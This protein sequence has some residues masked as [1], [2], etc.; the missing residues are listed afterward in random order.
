MAA[1]IKKIPIEEA[2]GILK[3]LFDSSIQRA[4]RIYQIVHIQSL[5]PPVLKAALDIYRAIM[6]GPSPLSRQ[7]REMIAT[8]VSSI[9][10]CHY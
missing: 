2:T 7:Q 1:C 6:Y 5:N 8:V 10:Q 9:N 4:G 3:T